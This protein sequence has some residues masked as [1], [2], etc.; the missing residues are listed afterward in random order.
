VSITSR[1]PARAARKV[2]R[3]AATGLAALIAATALAVPA[4]A[5]I[6][7]DH[8]SEFVSITGVPHNADLLLTV[9]GPEGVL[10]TKAF[11][12]DIEVNHDGPPCFDGATTPDLRPGDTLT[13]A[14]NVEGGATLESYTIP[15]VLADWRFDPAVAADPVAG[16]PASPDTL[17]ISGTLPA[18]SAGAAEIRLGGTFPEDV[19]VTGGSLDRG[20]ADLARRLLITPGADSFTVR[21]SP[22]VAADVAEVVIAG[23][24]EGGNLAMFSG[25]AGAVLNCPAIDGTRAP[26]VLPAL[27]PRPAAPGD[28]DGDGVTNDVDTCPRV[29]GAINN[30]GCPVPAPAPVIVDRPVIPLVPVGG[31]ATTPGTGG[32]TGATGPSP[33]TG[34]AGAAAATPAGTV[35][36]LG[37]TAESPRVSGLTLPARVSLAR[38][39][40]RGLRLAMRVPNGARMARIAVYRAKN[41]RRTGAALFAVNRTVPA[42][43]VRLTVSDRRLLNRLRRG[44]HVV[45]VR[46]GASRSTLGHAVSRSFQVTR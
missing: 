34:A 18:G 11:R 2:P 19:M 13:I 6:E 23:G 4:H 37:V 32:A 38:V 1:T 25:Q 44:R 27:P 16:T 20:R 22:V 39:R 12:G 14:E 35:A 5:A 46:A 8:G 36:V 33:V 41:G 42:G 43:Q 28:A 21:V 17:V 26:I 9:T 29:P 45:E 10:G 3:A 30:D 40:A 15:D 7:V 31:P 24:A